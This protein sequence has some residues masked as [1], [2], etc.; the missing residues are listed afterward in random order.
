YRRRW[1]QL[2]Q[3]LRARCCASSRDKSGAWGTAVGGFSWGRLFERAV[4][5]AVATRVAPGVPPSVDSV[6]ADSSSALLREQSRQEWRLGY[7]RRWIQLG[8]TLR[9]RCCASSRDKSG[10]WGT[11]V[12]GFSWGR[13]FER[14]VAWALATRG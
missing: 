6:G 11:A 10:A 4:A 12:G 9:A 5:R 8:Q 14:A 3:T 13:L 2:G 7:R 1:I